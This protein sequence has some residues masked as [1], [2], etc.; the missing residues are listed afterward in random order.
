M[1]PGADPLGAG[2]NI[3]QSKIALGSAG[4]LA[5]DSGRARKASCN[6]C[7][8]SILIYFR[9]AGGGIRPL[10]ARCSCCCFI[11]ADPYGYMIALTCRNQFGRLVAFGLTTS[12]FLMC[13]SMWQW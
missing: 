9:G 3:V 7:R 4:C 10:R 5:K 8:K 1:N 13:S 6:F 11:F 12:F 2:Y